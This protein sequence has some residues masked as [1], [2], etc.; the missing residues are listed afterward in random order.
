[1][2]TS[3][4]L[5][6]R[7]SQLALVQ[8]ESVATKLR[9]A[10]PGLEVAI[11][12]IVTEGDRNR[13]TPLDKVASIGIFV[14]E[15]EAALLDRRIDIAVHS[16]KDVPTD[17]PDGLRLLAVTVREDTR[18]V[19]VA[20]AGLDTLSTGSKIGTGSLRRAVQ[21]T[22][23]R[24]DL[25]VSSIR[26]NVETRLRK[27]T[28]GELDGVIVAAAAIARLNLGKQVT[29]YLPVDRFLPAVGQGA[30]VIEG[31]RDDEEVAGLV[32][33]VNHFPTWYSV[34][35]ERAFLKALGGGCR[36]PIAALASVRGNVIKLDGMIADPHGRKMLS[37]TEKGS[38]SQPEEVG[39]RLARRLLN[40]GAADFIDEVRMK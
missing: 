2:R 4:V 18:D 26:G 25:E 8:S 30:L 24:P 22:H 21:L 37:G 5:G 20:R 17:I 29:E 6:S 14:K 11:R 7:R 27:V 32:K 28:S 10:N 12:K 38:T 34:L 31:R 40:Q 19:L 16:L 23:Y 13:R 35:A 33:P 39:A 9:E 36:A 15:L 1:M 3:I